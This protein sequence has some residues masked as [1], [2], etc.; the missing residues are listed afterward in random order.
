MV[1]TTL[2]EHIQADLSKTPCIL[3][4]PRPKEMT[5]DFN[6]E[7]LAPQTPWDVWIKKNDNIINR[8]MCL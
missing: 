4:M 1:I 5:E 8:N 7:E 6:P 2:L 3:P